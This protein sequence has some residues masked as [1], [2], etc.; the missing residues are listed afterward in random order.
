MKNITELKERIESNSQNKYYGYVCIGRGITGSGLSDRFDIPT[1]EIYHACSDGSINNEWRGN[2]TGLIYYI[3]ESFY[4]THIQSPMTKSTSNSIPDASL[5]DVVDGATFSY[6]NNYKVCEF[7]N[8]FVL[9][10]SKGNGNM[11]VH[12]FN[13]KKEVLQFIKDDYFDRI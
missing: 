7:D 6:T 8:K 3:T 5:V 2:S 12:D 10:V 4:K 13:T 9:L 11:D 1:S